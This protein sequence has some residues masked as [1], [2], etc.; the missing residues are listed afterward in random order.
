MILVRKR[1]S[2]AGS[3][4]GGNKITDQE[5]CDRSKLID[6]EARRAAVLSNDPRRP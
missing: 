4:I 1:L 2:A 3:K 5:R 6:D